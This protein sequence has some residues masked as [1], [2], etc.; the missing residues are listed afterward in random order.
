MRQTAEGQENA[1]IDPIRRKILKAGAAA[2][3]IRCPRGQLGSGGG[4]GV[5]FFAGSALQNVWR[6]AIA[7]E[8]GEG[9]DAHAD[10]GSA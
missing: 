6:E 1:M 2:T 4:P 9:Q 3:V 7:A 8:K 10:L 5:L